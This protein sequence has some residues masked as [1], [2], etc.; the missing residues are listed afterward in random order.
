MSKNR[1]LLYCSISD[2]AKVIKWAEEGAFAWENRSLKAAE[3]ADPAL[4]KAYH[5]FAYVI[6]GLCWFRGEAKDIADNTVINSVAIKHEE[7][8]EI[9]LSIKGTRYI[10]ESGCMAKI[11]LSDIFIGRYFEMYFAERKLDQLVHELEQECFKYIDGCRAQQS[12]NFW[13]ATEQ[14]EEAKERAE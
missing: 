10:P 12:L 1:K 14:A 5:K 8:D 7:D 2:K 3:L 11:H 4:G 13:E 9:I 6:Q